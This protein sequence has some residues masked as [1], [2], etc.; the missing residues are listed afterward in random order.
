MNLYNNIEILNAKN[1]QHCFVVNQFVLF[2]SEINCN[3]EFIYVL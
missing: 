3:L 2:D 1:F